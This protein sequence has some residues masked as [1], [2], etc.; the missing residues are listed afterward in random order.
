[1]IKNLLNPFKNYLFILITLF[2]LGSCNNNDKESNNIE[3][4]NKDSLNLDGE[5]L[6][7][8]NKVE[9][10]VGL[11]DQS[12]LNTAQLQVQKLLESCVMNNYEVAAKTIMYR[13]KDQSRMGNDFFNNA[14]PQ[15]ANT[16]KVTCD[17]IKQWLGESENYEF[18]SYQEVET[19]MGP[20]HVVEVMFKKAK[21]GV[22]R[23]FFYLMDTPKGMLLV[24]MI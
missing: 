3:V 22:N 5:N 17:V 10:L 8:N 9:Q 18:I 7:E 19:D 24:N 12:K 14:N 20:Q 1:M 11:K 15:E 21:L 23:H 4:E 13:G 6:N 2:T 16:V